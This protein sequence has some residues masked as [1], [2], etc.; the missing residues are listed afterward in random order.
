MWYNLSTFQ[1]I[2][3]RDKHYQKSLFCPL[4]IVLWLNWF[5]PYSWR[6]FPES[7]LRLLRDSCYFWSAGTILA[8]WGWVH[9]QTYFAGCRCWKEHQLSEFTTCMIL[10]WN[11]NYLEFPSSCLVDNNSLECILKIPRIYGPLELQNVVFLPS[12]IAISWG[13]GLANSSLLWTG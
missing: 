4:N 9:C 11:K 13:H 2:K 7:Y 12:S 6:F 8:S 10:E 3:K 1:P 5:C